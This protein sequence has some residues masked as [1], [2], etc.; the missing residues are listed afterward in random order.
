MEEAWL[1]VEERVRLAKTQ[2]RVVRPAKVGP[3]GPRIMKQS[4]IGF[5]WSELKKLEQE[6]KT[7][8]G[9]EN[10]IEINCSVEDGNIYFATNQRF[11]SF[12]ESFIREKIKLQQ[13]TLL[14]E[15]AD[16]PLLEDKN[17]PKAIIGAGGVLEDVILDNEFSDFMIKFD[18]NS[19]DDT[20]FEVHNFAASQPGLMK[21][22][23]LKKS[24]NSVVSMRNSACAREALK[25]VE[26]FAEANQ[27]PRKNIYPLTSAGKGGSVT[28]MEVKLSFSRRKL[29][30]FGFIKF[31]CEED[32]YR[33]LTNMD[34]SSMIFGSECL[35][36][37]ADRKGDRTSLF[38]ALSKHMVTPINL[39]QKIKEK[40]D[41]KKMSYK[42]VFIPMGP[43][44]ESSEREIRGL[45]ANLTFLLT[46]SLLATEKDFDVDIRTP[47]A[48]TGNWFV[49]MKFNSSVVGINVGN[50]LKDRPNLTIDWH[51]TGDG[52]T[53]DLRR[54]YFSV[55]FDLTTS[56]SCP[57]RIFEV[58]KDTIERTV[59]EV[60]ELFTRDS[61]RLSLVIKR[62]ETG[63]SSRAVFYIK[64]TNVA[65]LA[66]TKDALDNILTGL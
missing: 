13:K 40:L 28:G 37:K 22:I 33:V 7:C 27:F 45:K 19:D 12:I 15:C 2:E 31:D 52:G 11:H 29:Q 32:A 53:Q 10:F 20:F 14:N 21:I 9:E 55:D 50:Y 43:S 56:F 41:E 58:L 48:N 61:E 65:V 62:F 8:I 42:D 34:T 35:R 60:S 30:K 4:I 38:F 23:N 44:Y 5:K 24:G 54:E 18:N 46:S 26:L 17:R 25:R 39:V 6:L 1:S 63:E 51:Q 3:V 16:I 66:R 47:K 36:L 59:N 64:G 57:Q 49:K